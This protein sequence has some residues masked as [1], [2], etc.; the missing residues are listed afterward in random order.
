MDVVGV[1]LVGGRGERARPITVKARGYL[2]SKAAVSFCGKRLIVWLLKGMRRQAVRAFVVVD[3]GKENR[4]QTKTLSGH[5]DALEVRMR[6]GLL[7]R[8]WCNTWEGDAM[9][10]SLEY[11]DI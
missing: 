3:Q 1:I 7:Q 4:Y 10:R 6:A 9:L 11:W 5:G 2:R 8:H